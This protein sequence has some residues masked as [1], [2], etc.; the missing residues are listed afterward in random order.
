MPGREIPSGF[1]V[2]GNDV[3]KLSKDSGQLKHW[4]ALKTSGHDEVGLY[5]KKLRKDLTKA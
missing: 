1:G 3:K 4:Y 2:W 5:M